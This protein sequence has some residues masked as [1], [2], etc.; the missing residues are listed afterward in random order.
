[1]NFG[2]TL[3]KKKKF[4]LLVI[5]LTTVKICSCMTYKSK[6][7]IWIFFLNCYLNLSLSINFIF[8]FL[9]SDLVV[10]QETEKSSEIFKNIESVEKSN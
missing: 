8:N 5:L 4:T 2:R 6:N 3:F 9:K 1:M 7:S 10:F